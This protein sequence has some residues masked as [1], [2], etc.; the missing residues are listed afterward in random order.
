MLP[1]HAAAA[2][3]KRDKYAVSKQEEG[4]EASAHPSDKYELPF[5]T[6]VQM[7]ARSRHR[8]PGAMT[9]QTHGIHRPDSPIFA[10]GWHRPMVMNICL[11]SDPTHL[12]A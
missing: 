9:G 11:R 5:P 8:P 2:G 12:K 1:G 6:L 10:I 3:R 4:A 7:L